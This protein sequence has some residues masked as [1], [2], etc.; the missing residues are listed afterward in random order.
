MLPLVTNSCFRKNTLVFCTTFNWLS[1]S[2]C[3]LLAN[4]STEG[5]ICLK[6]RR[7]NKERFYVLRQSC[8]CEDHDDFHAPACKLCFY[9]APFPYMINLSL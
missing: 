3:E 7:G 6:K 4:H 9:C 8:D 1:V 2:E 5:G